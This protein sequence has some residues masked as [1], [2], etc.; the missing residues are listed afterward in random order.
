MYFGSSAKTGGAE[1]IKAYLVVVEGLFLSLVVF[2]N[3]IVDSALE[4]LLS[5]QFAVALCDRGA[6]AVGAGNENHVLVAQPVTEKPCIHVRKNEHAAYMAEMQ[7]LVAIGHAAGYYRA[8]R[9]FRARYF[10]F[11]EF[12]FLFAHCSMFPFV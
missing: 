11:Y 1:Y 4:A 7:L 6:V 8:L 2:F 5:A 3:E 12:L 9:E 10:V